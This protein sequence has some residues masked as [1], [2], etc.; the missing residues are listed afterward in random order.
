MQNFGSVYILGDVHISFSQN[1]VHQLSYCIQHTTF[2]Q[3]S[4]N[5]AADHMNKVGIIV[6]CIRYNTYL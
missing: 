2:F 1:N 6:V 3:L 4:L 5:F